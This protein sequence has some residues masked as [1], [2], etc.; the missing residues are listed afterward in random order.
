MTD[1]PIVTLLDQI[2]RSLTE[3][4]TNATDPQ[5]SGFQAHVLV[6]QYRELTEL[7]KLRAYPLGEHP[8]ERLEHVGI[9]VHG[10]DLTIRGREHDLFVDIDGTERDPADREAFPLAVQ[11]NDEGETNYY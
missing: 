8:D 7:V 5:H 4:D 1:S 11:V 10:V 3:Y 9:T 6:A 2:A